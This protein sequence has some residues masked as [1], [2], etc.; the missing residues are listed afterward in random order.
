MCITIALDAMGGDFGPP[1][2]VE[3]ANLA[4]DLLKKSSTL[5]G[6]RVEFLFFGQKERI[7]VE[8]GKYPKLAE[9]SKV[10]HTDFIVTNEMKPIEALRHRGDSNLGMAIQ[11][12]ADKKADAVVSAANT[13]AYIALSKVILETFH[14]IDRPA[15]PAIMPNA[16]GRSI[17]LDLG[18][19]LECSVERL[20][21]FALMGE[22]LARVLLKKNSPS[23]GLL[24]VGSEEMKGHAIVQATGQIL[25]LIDEKTQKYSKKEDG[26]RFHF[27]GFV[28]GDDIFKGVTDVVVTDGFSGNIA[29]KAIEG[30][31][32]FFFKLL[33]DTMRDSIIWRIASVG[34]LPVL[35]SIKKTIDPRLYNGAVFLGLNKIAVKSHGGADA[36]AF[37]QAIKVAAQMVQSDFIEDVEKRL[38]LLSE[39]Q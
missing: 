23:V 39:I 38:Q 7:E 30:A 5:G 8:L 36:F 6:V 27:H 25:H 26:I 12:V 15:I 3:G 19:N 20:T 32:W 33:R 22:A 17:V 37:A 35:R 18:A 31:I 24:N 13:G 4:I 11:S 21:Q 10:F 29:L 2:T 16:N 34:V 14:L 9:I 28:E 1:V